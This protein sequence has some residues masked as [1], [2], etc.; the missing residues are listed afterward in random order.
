MIDRYTKLYNELKLLE[1]QLRDQCRTKY[2]QTIA[3]RMLSESKEFIT[4]ENF[5]KILG[6]KDGR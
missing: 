6:D 2:G 3:I 4:P 5:K 1:Y